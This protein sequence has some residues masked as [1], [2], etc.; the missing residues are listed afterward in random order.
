MPN[1]KC[2]NDNKR[3]FTIYNVIFAKPLLHM[4]VE[5]QLVQP[6]CIYVHMYVRIYLVYKSLVAFAVLFIN[7]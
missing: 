1:F 6:V 5:A 7:L 2:V 3:L 4:Y